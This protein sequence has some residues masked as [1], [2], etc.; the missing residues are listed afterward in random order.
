MG[1]KLACYLAAK[2]SDRVSATVLVAPLGP[3][4]AP[5]DRQYGL[6][7]C[8]EAGDWRKNEAVFKNWFAPDANGEIVKTCCQTIARTPLRALEAT[9]ELF[10]WTSLALDIGTL[11][12]PALVVA[13]GADPVYGMSYQEREMLPFLNGATTTTLPCGHFVPL[14]K[15]AKL[16]R[17][18]SEFVAKYG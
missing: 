1:G 6:Q 8:R 15:P 7:A 2:Y 11:A 17:T 18:I 14:E 4:M 9:G 5:V 16:A 3:G 13:G 10:L 12:L